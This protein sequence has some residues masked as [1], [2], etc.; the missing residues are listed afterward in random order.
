MCNTK[1]IWNDGQCMAKSKST[2]NRCAN[3]VKNQDFCFR[4]NITKVYC[5]DLLANIKNITV[6]KYNIPNKLLSKVKND[7]ENYIVNKNINTIEQ[8]S[9]NNNIKFKHNLM[10]MSDSFKDIKLEH[11]IELDKEYWDIHIITSHFVQQLNMSNMECPYPVY[12]NNPFNRIPFT[13][14]ALLDLRDR[15]SYLNMP[16]NITLRLLLVQPINKLKEL[17]SDALINKDKISFKLLDLFND[18]FRFKIINNKNSQNQYNGY[19]TK[20]SSPFDK[21]EK[22]YHQWKLSPIQVNREN[23]IVINRDRLRLEVILDTFPQDYFDPF[24]SHLLEYL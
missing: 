24:N 3:K 8:I 2:G 17:Y 9:T 11:Q 13:P 7:I 19:W 22:A 15:L 10:N 6:K 16:I 12:P 4:H 21:F 5:K 1:D 20:K 14:Q 23:Q 18:N